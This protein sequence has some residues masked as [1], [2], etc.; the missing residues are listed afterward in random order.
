MP[1]TPVNRLATHHWQRI[2]RPTIG[3]HL[4]PRPLYESK[5]SID[6]RLQEFMGEHPKLTVA[7]AAAVGM[8]LGWMVKRK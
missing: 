6:D 3:A 8:I 4:G 2:E 1:D 5:K 7:A